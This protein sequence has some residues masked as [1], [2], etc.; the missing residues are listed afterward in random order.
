MATGAAQEDSGATEYPL[1][2]PA[3]WPREKYRK[4]S[5]FAP[6]TV[7]KAAD[8]VFGEL[9][10]LRVRG[11]VVISTN[12][13][14]VSRA[15]P[16]DPGVAVYFHVREPSRCTNCHGG[17]CSACPFGPRVLACDRWDRVE[18]N[19]WAVK[20]HIE[21]LRGLDR[22]GVGTLERIF[23]GYT[24]LPES[25]TPSDWR[26]VLGLKTLDRVDRV[27]IHA[28]FKARALIAHPDRGGSNAAMAR[29]NAARDAALK[30][31]GE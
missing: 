6:R 27:A 3:G 2:W 16:S 10:R 5:A 26:S 15:Q 23:S 4:R 20:L 24:A 17:R 28:A 11:D 30:E 31:I 19:L 21:A 29:L 18:D 9:E 13:G 8:A 1:S 22:W 25:A 14:G 12:V 7:H